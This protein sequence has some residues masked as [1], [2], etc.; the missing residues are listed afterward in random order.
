MALA[1][2][3]RQMKRI[4]LQEGFA[5]VIAKHDIGMNEWAD[6]AQ[7]ARATVYALQNPS[8]HPRRVGGM[9]RTTA[10]RLVNAFS[11]RTGIEPD[12]AWDMLM[13]EEEEPRKRRKKSE[14]NNESTG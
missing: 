12:T 10:W 7:V 9:H 11:Q 6:L 8:T 3:G 4:R 5:D 2:E 14:D 1:L 13:V